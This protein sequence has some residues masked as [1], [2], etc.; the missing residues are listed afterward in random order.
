MMTV[1]TVTAWK[2]WWVW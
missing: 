2:Q 1:V